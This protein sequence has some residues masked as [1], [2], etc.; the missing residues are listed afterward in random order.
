MLTWAQLGL[1]GKPC[2]VLNVDGYFDGLLSFVEHAV[3]EGFVRREHG[4]MLL[5][6]SDSVAL[7]DKLASY[8]APVVDKWLDRASTWRLVP[9]PA[10]GREL[11]LLQCQ[12]ATIL[13]VH[14]VKGSDRR[15]GW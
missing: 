3:A 5:V 13:H 12:P 9:T 10:S 2:G 7:L 6:A 15:S 14:A 1:H 4:R 11:T 8:Q